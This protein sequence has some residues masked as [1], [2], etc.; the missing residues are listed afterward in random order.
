VGLLLT[1]GRVID[2][3]QNLDAALDVLLDDGRVQ[4]LER[5]I[6]PQG[7][8]VLDVTGRVVCPGFIDVHV[9]LRE[10]G[11]EY[12]ET[13]ASGTRAAAA[14]GFA[15]VCCMPNTEPA[16]DDPSV[17]QLIEGRARAACGVR[18]HSFGALSQANEGTRLAELGRLA[19]AG[20]PL[21]SDDAFPIQNSELMRYAM[22]Y[23]RMLGRG[24]AL[25]CEDK[26]L[27]GAGVMNEGP[28]AT[29]MGLRGM[30]S[31]AEDVMVAR[32][33]ELARLT[34]VRLHVCHVSTRGSVDLVRRAKRDGLPIT[35]EACP[36][37]FCLTDAACDGYETNAKVNPP[38]RSQR[39]VD[40]VLEGLADGT[41][42]CIATDH[43]PHAVQEK[44]CEFDRALF[45][46]VGLETVVP[47]ALDRLVRQDVIS[48]R[49]MIA[50]LSWNPARVLIGDGRSGVDPR[51]GTLLPGAP[52]D[53][54]VLDPDRPVRVDPE[55]FYTKSKN[56]PFAGWELVGAPA[57]TIV[58]GRLLMQDGEVVGDA[59]ERC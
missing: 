54:T 51:T 7:Y 22:E 28:L 13:I 12:K 16:I 39:D 1:G 59:C 44:E 24:V 17:A 57:A 38:L 42:D 34:G 36:H 52:G 48:L 9:H 5:G 55:R 18:V 53:V 32:N 56:T 46:L 41:L 37:H 47:L 27:S 21:F 4:A 30:P 50:K 29:R 40:A 11:Q 19:D 49:E 10:P 14:G 31:A 43:A 45:G 3:S 25:H 15:R 26:T 20:C 23:A 6:S 33:I 35:A 2:P 8:Q 58:A